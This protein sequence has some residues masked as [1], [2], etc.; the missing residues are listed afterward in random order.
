MHIDL[1][2]EQRELRD[3]LRTYFTD[4]MTP[5]LEAEVSAG[6]E[7]GGPLFREAMKKLGSDG[8]LGIGW[9]TEYGGQGRSAIEQYIFAE[10]AQ[11]SGFPLPFLTISTVGPTLQKYGMSLIHI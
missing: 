11:R 1:S 4:L 2:D 5:E 8:W 7:G 9:P 6:G 3:E 10:E